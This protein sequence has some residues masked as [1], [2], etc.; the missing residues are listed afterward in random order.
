MELL[1]KNQLSKI[2]ILQLGIASIDAYYEFSISF[3]LPTVSFA[4]KVII[5]H[6]YIYIYILKPYSNFNAV[7]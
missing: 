6:V 4:K 3:S 1:K 2:Y 7:I 5:L